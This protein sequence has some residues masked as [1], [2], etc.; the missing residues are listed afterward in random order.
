MFLSSE[1]DHDI[2]YS[3][4]CR[5]RIKENVTFLVQFNSIE[6]QLI[7][8]LAWSTFSACYIP[9]S[10]QVYPRMTWSRGLS[11]FQLSIVGALIVLILQSSGMW[12]LFL[13]QSKSSRKET[14][15]MIAIINGKML[16]KLP[17]SGS[18]WKQHN[19]Q[20]SCR[21]LPQQ[22][23]RILREGPHQLLVLPYHWNLFQATKKAG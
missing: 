17:D 20:P 3:N 8:N 5:S 10:S 14:R 6:L 2:S 16:M 22:I 12:I 1:Y 19:L 23:P 13:F 4:V 7:Y 21:S 18:W 9:E 11:S 15:K